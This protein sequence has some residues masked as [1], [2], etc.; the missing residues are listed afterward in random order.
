MIETYK[1]PVRSGFAAGGQVFR[2][3]PPRMRR[4][5]MALILAGLCGCAGAVAGD[6]AQQ[7]ATP[8][9]LM[10]ADVQ[11]E[12]LPNANSG[13]GGY[14]AGRHARLENDSGA[15]LR[16]F[17][18]ALDDDPANA[19]LLGRAL[20]AALAERDMVLGTEYAE[21]LL[22]VDPES[23]IGLLAL[24][25]SKALEGDWP[26]VSTIIERS[27]ASGLNRYMVPLLSGWSLVALGNQ[28]AALQALEPLAG[29][30]IFASTHDFHSGLMAELFGRMQPAES[31]YAGALSALRGGSLRVVIAA[32]GFYH[33]NG[34][35][36]EARAIYDSF[37]DLNPDTTFLDPA[38][39]RLDNGEPPATL[40]G[41]AN[42]GIA[43]ALYGAAISLYQENALEPALV[44]NQLALSL[45][46]DFDVGHMLL[47]D[48]LN[49]MARVNG[50]VEAY[51][52]VPDDSP[53]KWAVR[54]RTAN[55]LAEL[56]EIE[57]AAEQLKIMARERPERADPLIALA[58]MMRVDERYDET[59]E[60]YDLAFAR[61]PTLENRHWPLLYAR[62][63]SLERA[64]RWERA[65]SDFLRALELEPDQ[66]LVL[67]Y[68]GYS[69]V[70]MGRNL[71]E[72]RQ[73]IEKA[74]EQRPNDGYIVDSLGWVLY[75][76]GEYEDAVRFLERAAELRA[77]DPVILGHFGDGLWQVGRSAEARFQWRRALSFE[78]EAELDEALRRKIEKGLSEDD[79]ESIVDLEDL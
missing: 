22:V 9:P 11:A 1:S 7:E 30:S 62:G 3:L 41:N 72:A 23:P 4:G 29:N 47:G 27:P 58:D 42:E 66:P 69:W 12:E 5:G 78:P 16:Y 55:G 46:P 54:L 64:K 40:V 61:I 14:L 17:Q 25:V 68:L 59:I 38:Y 70:E 57:A 26:N 76:L 32:G 34:R 39:R 74:V 53:L 51:R 48:I 73:M 20:M 13:A 36:D 8:A 77:N 56:D 49:A 6:R 50:A 43:E 44:Y 24:S 37:L 75:R 67:N 2:C 79:A 15:A 31:G 35:L 28:D 52:A 65:E 10:L 63:M 45:R 18:R 71:D 60:A 33:R 21:R 19:E